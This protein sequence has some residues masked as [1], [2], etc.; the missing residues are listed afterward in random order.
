[1]VI[2]PQQPAL[3]WRSGGECWPL[4]RKF[5]VQ[6]ELDFRFVTGVCSTLYLEVNLSL[7]L[8]LLMGLAK[9]AG[10]LMKPRRLPAFIFLVIDGLL[11]CPRLT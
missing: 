11:A 9:V 8:E 10:W 6:L 3:E 2:L 5:P 1:M 4:R 7:N